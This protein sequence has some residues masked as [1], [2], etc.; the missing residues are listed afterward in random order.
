M[1]RETKAAA[2]N[3]KG[4]KFWHNKGSTQIT[5]FAYLKY[6]KVRFLLLG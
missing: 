6:A 4:D 3:R 1:R 5:T 2:G